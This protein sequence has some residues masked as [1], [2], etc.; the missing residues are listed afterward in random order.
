MKIDIETLRDTFKISYDAVRESH[1][2]ALEILDLYHNRQYTDRQIAELETRG[3]PKKH[4]MLLR[5]L[6]ACY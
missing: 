2:E 4:L 1:A 3:Q 6:G 5:C